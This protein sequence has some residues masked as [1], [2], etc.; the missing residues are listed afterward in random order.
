MTCSANGKLE[1]LLSNQGFAGCRAGSAYLCT[2]VDNQETDQSRYPELKERFDHLIRV[3]KG[4]TVP[5]SMPSN[6]SISTTMLQGSAPVKAL[7][8]PKKDD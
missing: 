6:A 7:K 8:G 2:G 3:A 1:S 4:E 5:S